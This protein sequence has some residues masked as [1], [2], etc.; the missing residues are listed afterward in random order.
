VSITREPGGRVRDIALLVGITERATQ[1][2]LKDLIDGGYLERTRIGRRNRYRVRPTGGLRHPL[3]DT[4][5]V[6]AL[7]DVLEDR[8]PHEST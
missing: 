4:R 2:I 1:A 6:G 7:L 8:A 5:T 3:F